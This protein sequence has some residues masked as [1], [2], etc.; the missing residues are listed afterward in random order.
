[1]TN[2]LLEQH[3]HQLVDDLSTAFVEDP[4]EVTLPDAP[5]LGDPLDA[6]FSEISDS[7]APQLTADSSP[8]LA[9]PKPPAKTSSLP[10]LSSKESLI[11][12]QHGT[13]Q[14]SSPVKT[15]VT[16]PP[17]PNYQDQQQALMNQLSQWGIDPLLD[18]L[19]G[20]DQNLATA[21]LINLLQNSQATNQ[22]LL[23][24]AQKPT[25][26][27]MEQGPAIYVSHLV[28]LKFVY[29][30][31]GAFLMG[32]D[33]IVDEQA[34]PDEQP[35]HRINLAGFWISRC[36]ITS[37]NYQNFLAQTGYQP[38]GPIHNTA[39]GIRPV[40]NVTWADA[41]AYCDWLTQRS[42]L[43]VSMPSEAE[44]EKSARGT[45][46]RRYPWGNQPPTRDFCNFSHAVP[47]GQSS[48]HTDSPYGCAD[49]AGNVWE[50]TRSQHRP[51]PYRATD[52]RE[53]LSGNAARVVR[54]LTFNNASL[55]MTRSAYRYQVQPVVSLPALGFRVVVSPGVER[56]TRGV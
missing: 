39:G 38:Q 52:G 44:W 31:P 21:A 15:S 12:S 6:L 56:S 54:G 19:A 23:T 17:L 42:G 20:T 45:D 33:P 49:M 28:G 37:A 41:L 43:P 3:I 7:A 34:T 30:P 48:P 8:T 32:S 27:L 9:E 46:G 55:S 51:Y 24:M 36:P 40:T 50:W 10:K 22:H 13:P 2:S 4:L 53:S 16:Q 47:V 5:A 11:P 29:V 25:S 1:M 18:T 35:Q 14:P 26:S